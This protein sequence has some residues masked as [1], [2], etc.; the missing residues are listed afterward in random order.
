MTNMFT[1]GIK[2]I[3]AVLLAW[4]TY[5]D[6]TFTPL[7]WVLLVLIA[8]DL[9]LNAH[10]EGQQFQK[11]GSMAISLGVPGYVAS[12]VDNPTLGKYLVAIMCLVYLQIVVP[13][14][15]QK[16]AS[17]SISK[18]KAQNTVDQAALTALVKKIEALEAAKAQEVLSQVAPSQPTVI[19]DE[20][21]GGK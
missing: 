4:F 21:Q 17:L 20:T 2:G 1:G 12:N 8:L 11:I 19:K 6:K 3:S 9:C 18:D 7:F 14:I 10:R 16:I 13:Q 5:I 15:V